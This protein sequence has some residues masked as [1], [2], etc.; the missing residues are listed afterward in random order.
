MSQQLDVEPGDE[1]F[2]EYRKYLAEGEPQRHRHS[3]LAVKSFDV[4]YK[5]E[6]SR[7]IAQYEHAHLL[8]LKVVRQFHASPKR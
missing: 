4:N 1:I 5:C 7:H 8:M 2:F 6:L 3:M